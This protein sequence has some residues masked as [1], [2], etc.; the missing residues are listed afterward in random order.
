MPLPS[1]V[2]ARE[3]A[4]LA[5]WFTNS[6]LKAMLTELEGE[7][8]ILAQAK[9]KIAMKSEKRKLLRKKL[10]RPL[11]KCVALPEDLLILAKF[12]I[13]FSPCAFF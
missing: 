12:I 13:G 6:P 7:M 2:A 4:V 11:F 3:A 1:E 5:S 9:K 10:N 8:E